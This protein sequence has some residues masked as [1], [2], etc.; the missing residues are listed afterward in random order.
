MQKK[1]D[2]SNDGNLNRGKETYYLE[3]ILKKSFNIQNPEKDGEKVEQLIKKMCD[4]DDY[5][6]SIFCVGIA[7]EMLKENGLKVDVL[8]TKDE[9]FHFIKNENKIIMNVEQGEEV[10]YIAL[11]DQFL[12]K[13]LDVF[14]ITDYEKHQLSDVLDQVQENSRS[15]YEELTQKEIKMLE[16]IDKKLVNIINTIDD[17]NIIYETDVDFV[18]KGVS[19]LISVYLMWGR[20]LERLEIVSQILNPLLDYTENNI[21][22]KFEGHIISTESKEF[23]NKIKT[24]DYFKIK[25]SVIDT[26]NNF[27]IPQNEKYD[28]L[29]E[30]RTLEVPRQ[31]EKT[32]KKIKDLLSDS[33]KNRDELEGIYNKFIRERKIYNYSIKQRDDELSSINQK[34]KVLHNDK[35][36]N[37]EILTQLVNLE[38][39]IKEEKKDLEESLSIIDEK[40]N[41]IKKAGVDMKKD[42]FEQEYI[43]TTDELKDYARE[44]LNI[45]LSNNRYDNLSYASLDKLDYEDNKTEKINF[46]YD[47]FL[48]EIKKR[49]FDLS[50]D[51][52]YKSMNKEKSRDLGNL[53]TYEP[54]VSKTKDIN[55]N[56]KS[57]DNIKEI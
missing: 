25:L 43:E 9:K 16:W 18:D 31:T 49:N 23:L 22:T 28:I 20:S 10:S 8:D 37:L 15:F 56:T 39:V 53:K 7:I 33:I 29:K 32:L 1:D 27:K 51:F 26:L 35:K 12:Y 55:K 4:V 3:D 11:L 14:E 40:L 44:L 41:F 54:E 52:F 19:D 50:D 13:L 34:K 17:E 42:E 2:N 30:I 36:H 5:I 38:D 47:K 46:E 21:L 24:P 45:K 6:K 57:V 48:E